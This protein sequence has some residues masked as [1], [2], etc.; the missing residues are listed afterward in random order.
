MNAVYS[1]DEM[2]DMLFPVFAQYN[3]KKAVLFGSYGK[4]TAT[5]ASDVDLFVDSGLRGLKFIDFS[6]TLHRVLDKEVDVLDTTHVEPDSLIARE[7]AR[8]GVVVYEK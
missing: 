6:E 3:I 2:K 8:T 5:S 7:I 4:R 1:I